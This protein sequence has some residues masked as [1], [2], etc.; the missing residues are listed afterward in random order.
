MSRRFG[1]NVT[2]ADSPLVDQYPKTA[3]KLIKRKGGTPVVGDRTLT[4]QYIYNVYYWFVNIAG[5]SSLATTFLEKNYGFWAAFL[6]PLGPIWI[7]LFLLLFCQKRFINIPPQ[8]NILPKTTKTL[9]AAARGGFKLSSASPD[10]QLE[11]YGKT[12]S[13]DA[14]FVWEM[15]RGL[16]ACRVM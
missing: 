12:V 7:P 1:Y 6:L 15:H 13:W 11:H 10:Y 2:L 9:L 16:I 14:T 8:G 5:L 4:I 3:P